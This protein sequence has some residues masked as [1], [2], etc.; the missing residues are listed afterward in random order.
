MPGVKQEVLLLTDGRSNCGG[1]AL[2]AA[3]GLKDKVDVYAL[4]IGDHN[5]RGRKEL[6]EYA[7]HPINQHLF[8]VRGFRDLRRLVDYIQ[9]DLKN[10]KC[11]PFDLTP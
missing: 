9:D 3:E 4:T 10:I 7:S 1:D 8:A 6:T 5:Y 11:A 2:L